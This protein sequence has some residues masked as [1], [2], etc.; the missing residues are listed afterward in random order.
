[1][2]YRYFGTTGMRVSAIGLGC[3]PF[4]NEV[5]PAGAEA[6]VNQAIDLGVTYFDTADSYFDGRSEDYLGRAL[7]GKR[8]RVIVATKV[9]N[10]TGSGPND[11]GT[12]RRHLMDAVE[13]S[14]RRLQTDYIDVYQIHSPDRHTPV[15]ETMRA[16]DDLVR[17][18]KVRYIGCSNYF[19]WEVCEAIW[20]A[21]EHHLSTFVSCQEF[22]NLL[23][24]DAEKRMVPFCQKYGLA[25]IPYFPLAGAML[26]G[27]YRHNAEPPAGSRGA[28]RPSFKR[29]DSERNWAVQEQLASF[30]ERRG[31]SLPELAVAWL[32]T[33]PMLC[34]V[35]AGAD[36][37]EHIAA[38]VKALDLH[39]SEQDLEE[40][41]AITLVDEDRTIAPVLSAS[42]PARGRR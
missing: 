34:T 14:L 16:L 35:I 7:R 37:A 19:E 11:T 6:I 2:E 21:R 5:D 29:W 1:M 8:D 22:Y 40:I 36:R 27:T 31:C 24:R 42:R 4:G 30:A 17:Q 3:N 23:Y 26:S 25:L 41:D 9:G 38:N 15:E 28:I 32:L 13:A 33:R 12:S 18:G 10:A 39:L 20:T